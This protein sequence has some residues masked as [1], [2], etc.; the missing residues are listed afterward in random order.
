MTIATQE[1]PLT[2]RFL[3]GRLRQALTHREA[4][5]V[6][7][8]IT[9]TEHVEDGR[10][11]LRR[12]TTV[13]HSTI[14]IEG[15]ILRTMQGSDKR[16]IL[17]THVPGDFIDMHAFALK[18]LD[19][20]ITALGPA[21]VGYARH[22]DLRIMMEQE[23]HLARLFWFSTLLDAAI[24]RTWILKMGELRV[25]QRIAHFICEMWAK[26]D[27]VGLARADG[28]NS[29]L[30]QSDLAEITGSTPIH[31]NRMLRDLREAALVEFRR[32]RVHCR[33]RGRLVQ[34]ARFD[35]SYLYG[36][37]DLAMHDQLSVTAIS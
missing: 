28:F 6:E 1:F 10:V 25:D 5:V 37:G 27:M 26:L 23:P 22:E 18:R 35:P 29:P 13:E 3:M 33:D 20:D 19:H 7:S 9:R 2:G 12:G 11:L 8:L 14:L 30:R 4:G 31:V 16:H 17:A 32:G 15:Y 34:F 24:H 21:L 36:A